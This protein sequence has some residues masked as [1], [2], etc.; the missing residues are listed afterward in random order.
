MRDARIA[1]SARIPHKLGWTPSLLVRD[2]IR[3]QKKYLD[4]G[5]HVKN[6]DAGALCQPR[7]RGCHKMGGALASASARKQRRKAHEEH[8]KSGNKGQQNP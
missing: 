7:L 3:A 4:P 2:N 1:D 6:G 5:G 8:V